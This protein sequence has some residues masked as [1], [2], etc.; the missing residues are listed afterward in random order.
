VHSFICGILFDEG[1]MISE[2]HGLMS[3]KENHITADTPPR[4]AYIKLKGFADIF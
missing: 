2:L 4:S 1:S 3:Q